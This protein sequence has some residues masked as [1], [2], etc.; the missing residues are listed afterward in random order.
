MYDVFEIKMGSSGDTRC[1]DNETT[2]A[3][4][5]GEQKLKQERQSD[6]VS[7]FEIS[8]SPVPLSVTHRKSP[9]PAKALVRTVIF[10]LSSAD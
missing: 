3:G 7:K 10:D 1:K 9:K 2:V 6:S 8:P 4:L 5:E